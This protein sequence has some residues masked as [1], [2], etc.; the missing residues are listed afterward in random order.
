[1]RLVDQW[2]AL[3]RR[4]P[5]TW[6]SVALRLRTEQP[7][8]LGE[9]ARILG[10]MGV[11]RV[12]DALAFDVRRAGGPAGPQAARRLFARLDEARIWSLLEQ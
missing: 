10:P 12:G 3:E 7:S 4:L 5:D 9:A 2:Q 6:E 8:E 11:G 1:M